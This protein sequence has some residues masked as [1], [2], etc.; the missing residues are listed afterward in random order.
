MGGVGNNTTLCAEGHIG[1]QCEECDYLGEVWK[2]KYAKTYALECEKCSQ[3]TTQSISVILVSIWILFA[4]YQSL[5]FFY[6]DK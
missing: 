1:A 3:Q 5:S 2:Q 6:Y 4:S